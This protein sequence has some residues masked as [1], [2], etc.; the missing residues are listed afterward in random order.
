MNKNEDWKR[1]PKETQS[2]SATKLLDLVERVMFERPVVENT[3]NEFRGFMINA[4]NIREL[5]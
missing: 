5:F 1:L 3:E 2:A 4:N